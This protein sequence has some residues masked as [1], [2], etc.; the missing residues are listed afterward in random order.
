MTRRFH[1]S[2]QDDRGLSSVDVDRFSEKRVGEND[3]MQ[4]R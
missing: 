2:A 1:K 3:D 4:P